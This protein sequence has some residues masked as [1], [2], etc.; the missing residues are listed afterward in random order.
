MQPWVVQQPVQV[1]SVHQENG[2]SV[3]SFSA[4]LPAVFDCIK[5][6]DVPVDVANFESGSL[7]LPGTHIQTTDVVVV[8]ESFEG[9][10]QEIIRHFNQEWAPR[11]LKPAHEHPDAWAT[12]LD[13]MRAALPKRHVEFPAITLEC[14]RAEVKRKKRTAAVGPDGVSRSDLLN[15][16]DAILADILAMIEAV[17]QGMPWPTQAVTGMIA[18]LAKVPAA[19]ST[20]QYRPITIFSI[21]Y[22]VWSSIRAKQ[23]L[24]F[25]ASIV[26]HS[27]L[28]NLPKRSPKQMWYHIQ[29]VVENA[30]ALDSEVAG[31][32]IDITRC[33]NA[34]PRVPLLAIAEHIG[35]PPCVLTPWKSALAQFQRRFQVRGCTGEALHSNCG[36]PEGCGLSTVAMAVCNLT[37]DMWLFFKNPSIQC[38]NYVDNI[39]TLAHDAATACSSEG[40]LT[41]FCQLLDLEVDASKSYCWST[42]AVG[43]QIIRANAHNSKLYARDLG[44]HM[45]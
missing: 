27:Q 7:T 25:L 40:I 4:P 37:C 17:E 20:S 45:N 2:G 32:V 26:P 31:C 29:E 22:R 12:V 18:A 5:V 24:K 30:H 1:T 41:E 21:V 3:L 36:F 15:L 14:W 28:G 35:L 39:E 6:N 10:V 11:W 13:F 23:S 38:W 44:G 33:F 16:P 42:T 8:V 43:R 9:E 34:L 19:R